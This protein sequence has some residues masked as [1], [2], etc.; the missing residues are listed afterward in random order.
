[1]VSVVF[2]CLAHIDLNFGNQKNKVCGFVCVLAL[3]RID[4]NSGYNKK[5]Y[6][7]SFVFL[8]LLI[9]T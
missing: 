8:V 4:L 1:M 3:A 7:V 5:T 6:M 9:L 2:L